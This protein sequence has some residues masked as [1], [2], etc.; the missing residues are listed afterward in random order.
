MPWIYEKATTEIPRHI[1]KVTIQGKDYFLDFELAEGV[2]RFLIEGKEN[3]ALT[4]I[5]WC[6]GKTED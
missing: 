2:K 6:G 1:S 5:K 3:D 4:L